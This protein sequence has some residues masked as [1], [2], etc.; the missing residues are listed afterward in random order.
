MMSLQ[1][2]HRDCRGRV[3][4]TLSTIATN[5]ATTGS[6]IDLQGFEACEWFVQ[7]GTVTDGTYVLS[8]QEGNDSGLSDAAAPAADYVLGAG[9]SFGAA[10]DSVVKRI[11]YIGNKRY[12]R[13]VITS[14]GVTTGGAF[15]AVAV[16][17]S[18]LHAPV[19]ND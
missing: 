5:T 15:S 17:A 1:D 12:A 2:L 16:V 18:P 19:A 13:V 9:T 3:G 11:G 10:D 7:S 4:K 14:T 6:I 8:I